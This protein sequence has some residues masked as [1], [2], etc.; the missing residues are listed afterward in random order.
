MMHWNLLLAH[1]KQASQGYCC[2]VCVCCGESMPEFTAVYTHWIVQYCMFECVPHSVTSLSRWPLCCRANAL[3]MMM[4]MVAVK[5]MQES[6][7]R[8]QRRD[9]S[10]TIAFPS[11][12]APLAQN[13]CNEPTTASLSARLGFGFGPSEPGHYVAS[14]YSRRNV[15]IF[16]FF[17]FLKRTRFQTTYS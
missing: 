9:P 5:F 13:E 6:L 12:P 2:C 1:T 11:P 14:H 16:F 7:Y 10:R 3:M 4:M 17:F 8:H 15:V